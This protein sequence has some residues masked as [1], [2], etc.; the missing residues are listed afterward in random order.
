M[1]RSCKSNTRTR[2][3]LLLS[4]AELKGRG[5]TDAAIQR[6]APAHD[7]E[8]DNPY[9]KCAPS[10][11]FWMRARIENIEQTEEFCTFLSRSVGR[12]AAAAK[13]VATKA[14]KIIEAAERMDVA[15]RTIPRDALLRAA[16]QDYNDY[17]EARYE[18]DEIEWREA[19]RH[20]DARFLARIQVN[21]LRHQCTEY[22]RALAET[23]G[24]V[25]CVKAIMRIRERVYFAIAT[26]YPWLADE[27][28]AQCERRGGGPAATKLSGGPNIEDREAR[29]A[30]ASVEKVSPAAALEPVRALVARIDAD[31]ARPGI[32]NLNSGP[33]SRYLY[34]KFEGRHA[35]R[36]GIDP[37]MGASP[38]GMA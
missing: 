5:W 27:C 18:R 2:R 4:R 35:L 34:Y 38:C 8:R 36:T 14:A 32:L 7:D 9:Y 23:A 16:I 3:E 31:G 22:D 15:V 6:F 25:G 24:R 20:S 37:S 13:A 28:R 17:Q 10:M 29:A 1:S 11:R 30:E 33:A 12:R 21:Y 19:T 26:D